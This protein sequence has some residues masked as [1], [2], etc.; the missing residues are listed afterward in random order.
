MLLFWHYTEGVPSPRTLLGVSIIATLSGL[1]VAR[2]QTLEDYL[3]QVRDSDPEK[4]VAALRTLKTFPAS[5][6]V[7]AALLG[8]LKDKSDGPRLNA[9]YVLG[10]FGTD[11]Y[12]VV[13]ALM[14]TLDD[15]NSM[16][17]AAAAAALG[18]FGKEA[19]P[20]LSKLGSL[21]A[22]TDLEVRRGAIQGLS[23]FAAA[24]IEAQA[25]IAGRL[26]DP[27]PYV[28]SRAV[29]A[30]SHVGKASRNYLPQF[31]AAL[32]DGSD[33]VREEAAQE[34][35]ALGA[36]GAPAFPAMIAASRNPDDRTP[37]FLKYAIRDIA[38]TQSVSPVPLLIAAL[39][40]PGNTIDGRAFAAETLGE[41]GPS[42]RAAEP[43]LLK[44]SKEAS[45][46]VRSA[47][48]EALAKVNPAGLAATSLAEWV[49]MLGSDDRVSRNGASAELVKA[50]AKAVPLLLS[51]LGTDAPDRIRIEALVTLGQI[52]NP[53]EVAIPVITSMLASTGSA[54][55]RV[56]ALVALDHIGWGLSIAKD[57]PV[58]EALTRALSDP[59]LRS[60]AIV[61]WGNRQAGGAAAV[62]AILEALRL[63]L[64]S[65]Q[66]DQETAAKLLFALGQIGTSAPAA[67]SLVT[68]LL[69]QPD[70]VFRA[71]AVFALGAMPA[72][73]SVAALLKVLHDPSDFTRAKAAE[74]VG[75]I[76]SSPDGRTYVAQTLPAL[77]DHVKDPAVTVRVAVVGALAA[78]ASPAAVQPV[79]EAMGDS[80][81][82]V[83]L[84]A[85]MALGNLVI[86][87]GDAWI[88]EASLPALIRALDDSESRVTWY[89][90]ICL[91][92]FGPAA[93]AALPPLRRTLARGDP[94]L[95][96]PV[97][98]AIKA[99]E[100]KPLP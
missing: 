92:S 89:A 16:V 77:L 48:A 68:S 28:R 33:Q 27:A 25:L 47:A 14:E 17:R 88:K 49:A 13:P 59:Q 46:R 44:A 93:A 1:G 51:L 70:A 5:D 45:A 64:N 6:A 74:A 10:Q 55:V 97:A 90:A 78:S 71:D 50:R 91:R 40:D 42:A 67:V 52:G 96:A 32:A 86:R 21:M 58:I 54:E 95:N 18:S 60:S 98:D 34:I 66:S 100:A 7:V 30:L 87:P 53:A 39:N 61:S 80:N 81:G 75:R 43:D 79:I 20:A 26:Q 11:P 85:T 65:T 3:K 31:I 24:N 94:F 15:E 8:A 63:S 36:A 4:R 9:A 29:N 99:I 69:D 72:A 76:L 84:S 19:A 56:A 57:G 82:Q 23:G 38:A 12:R 2:A 35:G 22:D 83:R 41:L 62:P 37:Y 73:D